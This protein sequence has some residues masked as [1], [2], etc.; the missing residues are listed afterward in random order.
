MSRLS[1]I[2]RIAYAYNQRHLTTEPAT[3][4]MIAELR[5]SVSEAI[6]PPVDKPKTAQSVTPAQQ[7]AIALLPLSVVE[8]EQQV[9]PATR[10]TLI[11]RELVEEREGQM[12]VV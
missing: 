1:L 3:A 4:E 2:R 7:K 10:R 11:K 8:W 9:H 6:A 5:E 12:C